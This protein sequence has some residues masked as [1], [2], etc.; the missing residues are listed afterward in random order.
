MLIYSSANG[1]TRHSRSHPM[2]VLCWE[3]C[4]LVSTGKGVQ[5]ASRPLRKAIGRSAGMLQLREACWSRL[6][7]EWSGLFCL[8]FPQRTLSVTPKGENMVVSFLR[9]FKTAV[10]EISHIF[11]QFKVTQRKSEEREEIEE[12]R[13]M[14][15]D[16]AVSLIKLSWAQETGGNW[17][18]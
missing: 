3:L 12:C 4:A 10:Q 9:M 16:Q 5:M 17:R 7:Y 14:V 13:R 6:C 11:S 1:H 8:F 18:Y 2:A 15:G